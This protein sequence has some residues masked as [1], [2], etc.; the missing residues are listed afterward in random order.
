MRSN[1]QSIYLNTL[2]FFPTKK[3]KLNEELSMESQAQL[4]LAPIHLKYN[5]FIFVQYF[6]TT[7]F[8]TNQVKKHLNKKPW[9]TED[10]K[11]VK[12]NLI[13]ENNVLN[14]LKHT[15]ISIVSKLNILLLKINLQI[16]KNPTMEEKLQNP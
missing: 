7:C 6:N 13:T 16:G 8:P 9:F 5:T 15:K 2:E 10:L 4:Y 3:D 14:K 1:H 11:L 12:E